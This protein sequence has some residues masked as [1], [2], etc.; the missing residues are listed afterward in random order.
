[1]LKLTLDISC[2]V[3]LLR[4]KTESEQNKK[5]LTNQQMNQKDPSTRKQNPY[6]DSLVLLN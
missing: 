5:T 4:K 2:Q 3:K 6:I 1:M